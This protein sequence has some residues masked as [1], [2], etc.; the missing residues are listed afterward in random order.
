MS[1][2]PILDVDFTSLPC[3]AGFANAR[4]EKTVVCRKFNGLNIDSEPSGSSDVT[5]MI[6]ANVRSEKVVVWSGVA[7]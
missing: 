2:P 4:A 7:D 6:Y 5:A 1:L 3:C